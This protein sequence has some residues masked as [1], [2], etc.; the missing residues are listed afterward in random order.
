MK[1][2]PALGSGEVGPWDP[3]FCSRVPVGTQRSGQVLL[4]RP[5]NFLAVTPLL[6]V[7]C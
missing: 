3:A 1:A 5:E 4:Q 2:L 7:P 6:P